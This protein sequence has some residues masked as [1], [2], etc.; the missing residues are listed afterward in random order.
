MGFPLHHLHDLLN[1]TVLSCRRGCSVLLTSRKRHTSVAQVVL[2]LDSHGLPLHGRWA[3][4][5]F[6]DEMGIQM[7]EKIPCK[8]YSLFLTYIS[9]TLGRIVR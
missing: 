1:S 6:L 4:Q 5:A 8:S 3:T 9:V 7:D 2:V